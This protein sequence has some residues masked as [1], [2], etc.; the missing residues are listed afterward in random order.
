[1]SKNV[2]DGLEL[3]YEL[4]WTDEFSWSDIVQ[5]VQFTIEGKMIIQ[6]SELIKGR[7]ITLSSNN[8]WITRADLKTLY[9]KTTVKNKEMVLT[10]NDNRSFLV[11]FRHSSIP[12]IEASPIK[13]I[14]N[15]QDSD[16]YRLTIKLM[17]I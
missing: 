8:A 14:T 3:P 1:M 7:P 12:V 10:L 13:D 11:C 17:V 5:N 4:V 9:N 16:F 2:L 6:E 15:L